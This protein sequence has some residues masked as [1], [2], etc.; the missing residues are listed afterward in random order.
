M[1]LSNQR[2]LISGCGLSWSG[3][4]SIV[5]SKILKI[6]GIDIL[7]VGRSAISNQWI[8]NKTILNLFKDQNINIAFVQLS[9]LGKL[10][11]E[12]T[13]KRIK[14]LMEKDSLRNFSFDN[15]W[16]SSSST[17]HI[18]KQ[19]WQK[20]LYSPSLEMEELCCKVLM[21]SQWCKSKNISL[22]IVQGYKILWS[23][24]QKDMLND[25]IFDIDK[26]IYQ[27]YKESDHYEDTELIDTPCLPF[28]FV[29]AR[30]FIH[31][32]IPND[33]N[34]RFEILEKINQIENA[35]IKA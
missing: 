22:I 17:E 6:A 35:T 31:L 26:S 14:E 21:L 13:P 8:I 34:K 11:V 33:N 23:D 28:Q 4:E 3:Q 29:L 24:K 5:W 2:V 16:P 1:L 15:I 32:I 12:L 7:D 19:L 27:Q 20:W 25:I 10:D 9:A 30:Q 18:S